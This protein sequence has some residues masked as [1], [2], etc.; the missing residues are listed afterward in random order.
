M[1]TTCQDCSCDNITLPIAIGPAGP[2]GPAGSAG[3]PGS[4]SSTVIF[5]NLTQATINSLT[6]VDFP[7]MTYTLPI[8]TLATNGSKLKINAFF[9]LLSGS[10]G[11][12]PSG[13]LIE[14]YV[15][16]TSITSNAWV[17]SIPKG[18]NGVKV[19]IILHRKSTTELYAEISMRCSDQISSS[20][21]SRGHTQLLQ[22]AVPVTDLSASTNIIKFRGTCVIAEDINC[23]LMTIELLQKS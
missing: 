10:L 19:E 18:V 13:G 9:T 14:L 5:S 8:N 11:G 7:G 20:L 15:D 23:E 17:L 6:P 12:F 4:G 2:A 22:T 3:A 16:G 21:T 1:C